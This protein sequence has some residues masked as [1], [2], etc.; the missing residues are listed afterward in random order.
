[1][2]SPPSGA[3]ASSASRRCP[4]GPLVER[5]EPVGRLI[6]LVVADDVRGTGIGPMLVARVEE[7][8]P[9][10]LRRARP[11]SSDRRNG[12]HGFYRHLG[13]ADVSRRCVKPIPPADG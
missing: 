8:A 2:A 10:G 13:F 12:A 7:R 9:R 3:D 6:A 4:S 5:D 11:H 1:V